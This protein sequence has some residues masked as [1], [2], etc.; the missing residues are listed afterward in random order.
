MANKPISITI[1]GDYT[2]KD[3]KR[4][5]RDLGSLQKQGP[6]VSRSIAGISSALIGLGA[7]FSAAAVVRGIRSTIDSASD[8]AESQSKIAVVFGQSATQIEEWSKTSAT[9]MLMSQQAALEAAGTFGNLFQAFGIGETA[10]QGMSTR[11]VELSADLASFNNTSVEDAILALR[12]GVS[13][14]MEP[15]KRY[16]VAL[17]DARLKMEALNM[18]IYD[19][20]GILDANQKSQAAYALI[21]KDTTLAQGDVARTADGYANTMRALDAA[22]QNASATI[23]QGFLDGIN[24]AT[25]AMGG[26]DGLVSLIDK[27]ADGLANMSAGF[28]SLAENIGRIDTD[29]MTPLTERKQGSFLDF[30]T[31]FKAWS[32][33]MQAFAS[34]IGM[35]GENTRITTAQQADLAAE[36]QRVADMQDIY[37]GTTARSNVVIRDTEQYA[38]AAAEAVNELNGALSAKNDSN[39]TIIS[40]NIRLRELR[41]SGPQSYAGADKK[42]SMD[43]RRQFGLD[44][45]ST[46]SGKYDALVDQGKLRKADRL[47]ST[48]REYL[49]GQGLGK[50]ASNVLATPPELAEAITAKDRARSEAGAN[51]WRENTAEVNN[52]F[53]I[54]VTTKTP[55]ET[56]EMVRRMTRL[57]AMDRAT[58]GI[59][60]A[61][62][63]A[64]EAAS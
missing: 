5:I 57:A 20:K 29:K 12:S 48:G 4:A 56:V 37:A 24:S 64:R 15:L 7:A 2:D 34:G 1:K 8:L 51:K 31:G 30:V 55:A 19:G 46:I 28:G 17:T 9:S 39:R 14:E 6:A 10:A 16:G 13:G 26:P 33:P 35:I 27:S 63:A 53:K 41:A 54:E 47:L 21:L 23:G 60:W 11:L 45:A 52:T 49:E 62:V 59:D 32:G 18:G 38:R 50:L 43:E 36:L 40:S 22:A 42:L 61:S 3:I 58:G 25:K 44:Y